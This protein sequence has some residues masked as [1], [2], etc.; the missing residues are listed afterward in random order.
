MREDYPNKPFWEITRLLFFGT[1]DKPPADVMK[2]GIDSRHRI[3][4]PFGKA[5]YFYSNAEKANQNAYP[6]D[7]A[8]EK[9]ILFGFVL[10]GD[11]A[12]KAP[13]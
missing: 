12:P 6:S 7:T 9:T 2:V 3:D 13:E 5:F 10:I 8:Q 11:A 1:K 4:G